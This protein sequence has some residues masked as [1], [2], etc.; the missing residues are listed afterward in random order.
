MAQTL[1]DKVW[2]AHTVRTLP[3]GQTQL[4]IG[5]HLIH[6][7]TTPQAFDDAEGAGASRCA[8]PSGPSAR[9]TTS[10]PP[11]SQARPYADPLAEEMAAHMIR[12]TKDFGLP[13]FDLDSGR[14]GIVHVIG[15]ELGLT[16][17]RH[18]HR[19][20]RQPHLHPRGRGRH[21]LRHRHQPGA[22]RPGHP[23]PGHGQAQAPPG[24]RGR[25]RSRRA[26]TPRTSSSPSSASS[27]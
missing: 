19:L 15:P 5:L 10:S 6:E 23:V 18:D 21:R 16:P 2:D 8:C 27:A 14:Q 3:S 22:R 11:P 4:F 20:R 12:N 9:S 24:A 26:C 7:V 13:L 17:A 25:A 1:L